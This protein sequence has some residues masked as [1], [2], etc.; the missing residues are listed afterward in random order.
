MRTR[1][2]LARGSAAVAG[3]NN[4]TTSFYEHECPCPWRGEGRCARPSLSLP[5]WRFHWPFI[6]ACDGSNNISIA[7]KPNQA[8]EML[9]L[10]C[11]RC[12]G[13]LVMYYN[14]CFLRATV[15]KSMEAA[16]I[17]S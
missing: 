9:I 16:D 8:E 17:H 6:W 12:R 4:C 14:K 13:K 3:V 2:T 10:P 5:L 1:L 11:T 15:A 7:L